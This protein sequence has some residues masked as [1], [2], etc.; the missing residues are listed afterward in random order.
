VY[1]GKK[2]VQINPD[3]NTY[4]TESKLIAA[5][6][7]GSERVNIHSYVKDN[8]NKSYSTFWGFEGDDTITL[9]L[10][11]ES[12]GS[13]ATGSD[14]K[15]QVIKFSCNT[16]IGVEANTTKGIIALTNS[17]DDSKKVNIV[18][19]NG[20]AIKGV[21]TNNTIT[22]DGKSISDKQIKSIS[23]KANSSGAITTTLTHSDNNTIS[24][25]FTPKIQ[26]GKGTTE[27]K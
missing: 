24:T 2:W 3:T 16:I 9:T 5:Q 8:N 4:I 11:E 17:G 12:S 15:R 21:A 6:A 7:D 23:Q 20:I 26:Y 13:T 25:T 1:N 22:V 14:T 18:G 19:A 27:T 10:E